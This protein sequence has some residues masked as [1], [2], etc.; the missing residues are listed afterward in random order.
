LRASCKKANSSP[1][2]PALD[3]QTVKYRDWKA[4]NAVGRIKYRCNKRTVSAAKGMHAYRQGLN[5]SP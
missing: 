2:F 5:Q 3:R 4:L 1:W